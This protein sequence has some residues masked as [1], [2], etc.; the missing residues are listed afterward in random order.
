[1]LDKF[2]I[3][4]SLEFHLRSIEWFRWRILFTYFAFK[5][6][7]C[8]HLNNLY[9]IHYLSDGRYKMWMCYYMRY[10]LCG[11]DGIDIVLICHPNWSASVALDQFNEI[12]MISGFN[13]IVKNTYRNNMLITV[14]SYIRHSF[15]FISLTSHLL[16]FSIIQN[17]KI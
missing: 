10:L 12:T 3:W 6:V 13:R 4:Y 17:I 9:Y 8:A 14:Y 5:A 2:H 15:I 7:M 1:M 16:E 11:V